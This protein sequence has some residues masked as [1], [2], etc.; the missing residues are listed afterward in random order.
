M[1]LQPTAWLKLAGA[2]SVL[3]L[4]KKKWSICMKREGRQKTTTLSKIAAN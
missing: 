4:T 2:G 1:L 3:Y